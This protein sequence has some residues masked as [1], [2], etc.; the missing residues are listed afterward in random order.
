MSVDTDEL[1]WIARNLRLPQ[2]N[3]AADELDRLRAARW[4]SECCAT[5]AL[6]GSDDHDWC[7]DLDIDRRAFCSCRCH[8]EE[9]Q[10]GS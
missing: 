6:A 4:V 10:N 9:N 1:R 5:E 8:T 2:V 3:E 7:P